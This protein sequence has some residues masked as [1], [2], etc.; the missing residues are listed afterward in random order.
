MKKFGLASWN[1]RW[2]LLDE[3]KKRTMTVVAL[4]SIYMLRRKIHDHGIV[5]SQSPGPEELWCHTYPGEILGK[6]T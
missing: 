6:K 2:E 5:T 1:V 3:W 4:Y